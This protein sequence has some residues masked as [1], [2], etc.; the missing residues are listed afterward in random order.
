MVTVRAQGRRMDDAGR[1]AQWRAREADGAAVAALQAALGLGEPLARVLCARG[2]GDVAAARSFLAPTLASL[3]DPSA[4]AGVDVAVERLER[5]L[6]AG[7]TIGVFGDYDVDGVASTTML[8]E[9]LEAVGARVVSTIPDRLLEGYGLSRPGVDRLAAAGATLVVAVDC[10][11]TAHDE[12]AYA[13]ARGVDVIVVDH[14]TVPVELPRAHA[15]INP[16][17]ADCARGSEDLCAAGVTFNLCLGLRRTLRA[18]GWFSSTRPEPDLRDA[19]DLV[20]LAT[21][22]DCV[23]LVGENRVLVAHGVKAMRGARR[24][25]LAALLEVANVDPL[26]VDAGT[27]GYQLGPRV[28]AAGRLGDAMQAVRLLRSGDVDETRALAR[29][30]DAENAARKDLEKR[31]VEEAVQRVAGS[32]LLQDAKVVVVGDEAWHPGVVGIVASRLV[33]KFGKPAVVVGE[34]GRGSGRSISAFHLHEA[35]SAVSSTLAGFGGH[36]H[37]AGVRV[38]PGG[39]DAFR[40]ALSAHAETRLQPSDL[41]RSQIHDGDLSLDDVT[42]EL[43]E[44]LQRAAP[45][46][47]GNGEPCFRVRGLRPTAIRALTGGHVKGVVDTRR[48]VEAIAF[49]AGDRVDDFGGVVDALCVPEVNEWRGAKTLQLR[50]RDFAPAEP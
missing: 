32:R 12:V 36:A 35:L 44:Q 2:V 38:P 9:L 23:R 21:V 15:V 46:G 1:R 8:S 28:N 27:L 3:P 19:L 48:R 39:L 45:F 18:R 6:S 42:F 40:D 22:A 10:G 20:A 13:K 49:G 24:R 16:H 37:A 31:I 30:L 7:E 4:L 14:H 5:A 25:G 11:V 34:G 26:K 29:R 41:A 47:R 33:D 50:V 43:V 17:R